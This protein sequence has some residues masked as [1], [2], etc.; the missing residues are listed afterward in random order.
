MAYSIE[1]YA[2]SKLWTILLFDFGTSNV[3]TIALVI[4]CPYKTCI[5]YKTFV[6]LYSLC[7]T[8]CVASESSD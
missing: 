8:K 2:L 1:Q 7:N 4:L 6:E 3:I 5:V